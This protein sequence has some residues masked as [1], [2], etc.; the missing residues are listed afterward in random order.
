MSWKKVFIISD[1]WTASVSR[2][3]NSLG[4]YPSLIGDH[5]IAKKGEW[6]HS[7][8]QKESMI[9]KKYDTAVPLIILT[10]IADM[11]TRTANDRT[12]Y[13]L[14]IITLTTSILGLFSI[15]FQR[16]SHNTRYNNNSS[17]IR[18]M[19]STILI[20]IIYGFKNLVLI[21]SWKTWNIHRRNSLF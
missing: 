11:A 12:T 16:Y 19:I 14:W 9:C 13:P 1:N 10:I 20:F 8:R 4:S 21:N 15:Y 3:S 6:W 18:Y 5:S 7:P 17:N 2:W